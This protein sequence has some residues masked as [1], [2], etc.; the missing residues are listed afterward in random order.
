[1]TYEITP[2]EKKYATLIIVLFIIGIIVLPFTIFGG[3]NFGINIGTKP[4]ITENISYTNELNLNETTLFINISECLTR[5]NFV[6]ND[7]LLI[8]AV[9]SIDQDVYNQ[10]G[11]PKINITTNKINIT[12]QSAEVNITLSKNVLYNIDFRSYSGVMILSFSNGSRIGNT[13]AIINTGVIKLNMDN[14]TKFSRNVSANLKVTSGNIAID[15]KK[16]TTTGIKLTATVSTGE[17]AAELEDFVFSLNT[18][19]TKIGQTTD[20]DTATYKMD[21][22]AHCEQ[23]LM[24]LSIK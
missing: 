1:M 3:F 6:D 21:I 4:K 23:G 12:Y 13:T 2:K 16:P 5:I 14:T 10:Y 18:K 9:F 19:T 7:S 24:A 22:F 17:L 15:I 8:Q 20:Y 11:A